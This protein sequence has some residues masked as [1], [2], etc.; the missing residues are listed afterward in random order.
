MLDHTSSMPLYHQLSSALRR[1][2]EA[3]VWVPDQAIPPERELTER[4]G[5]SRITVRQALADLVSEGVLYRKHGRGTFVA[6]P[7][8]QPIAETLTELTGH[9]EELQRRGLSPEVNVLAIEH[10]PLPRD[11]AGALQ[12]PTDSGSWWVHRQVNVDGVAL[13]ISETYVPDDLQLPLRSEELTRKAIARLLEEH[14][15]VPA[16]GKQRIAAGQ[17][18][19][20]EANLLGIIPG[21]PVLVVT[22]LIT[23]HDGGPLEWSRTLYRADRYEYEVELRRR[24]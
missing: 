3:G 21:A 24:R 8:A 22:R 13:L 20:E 17:A 9:V 18:G 14:G 6:P 10:R 4:F 15:Y 16:R 7:V 19:Q 11:V 23:G 12:R 5:V 2:I 1:S